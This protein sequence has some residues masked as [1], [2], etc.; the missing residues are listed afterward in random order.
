MSS[1]LSAV[2]ANMVMEDL[3]QRA[4]TSSLVKPLF[5]KGQVEDVVSAYQQTTW[6]AY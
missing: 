5:W 1:P 4:M 2:I 3:E 6:D